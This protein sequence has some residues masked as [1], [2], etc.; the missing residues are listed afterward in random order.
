VLAK[1]RGVKRNALTGI[2]LARA[3]GEQQTGIVG[4]QFAG[5]SASSCESMISRL[6]MNG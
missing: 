3:D 6:P 2:L 1:W 4:K 5:A